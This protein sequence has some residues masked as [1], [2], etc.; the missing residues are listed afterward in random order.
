MKKK[1]DESIDELMDY[2]KKVY[3]KGKKIS[4]YTIFKI[5]ISKL[6]EDEI[7][8]KSLAVAF[9]F[10]LAVFPAIIFLFTLIPYIT[11]IIPEIDS[12]VIMNFL[13]QIMPQNM[14]DVTEE[15][16]LDLVDTKRGGLLSIGVLSALFLSTN[17]FNTLIKTFNS[18][19]RVEENRGFFKTRIIALILT[20]LS[21]FIAIF[22]IAVSIIGDIVITWLNENNLLIYG[23]DYYSII[24][25]GII[26]LFI[27][28]YLL[29]TSMYYF[30]PAVHNKWN[31][32]SS[33]ATIAAIGCV[34]I[35]L[36]FSFYL[37][38]FSVYNKVYGSIGAL[39]A[40][41]G[42]IYIFSSVLLVGFE[43]NTSIDLAIKKKFSDKK[44]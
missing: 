13:A 30:A 1:I 25:A 32:F 8:E 37:N 27:F 9:S 18:C 36:I 39:I 17:G 19:H 10:T 33:G 6:I 42:Y 22:T 11:N 7:F 21:S 3:L 4:I 31:F 43:W 24:L 38:N 40:F 28:F 2:S 34:G 20:L 12:D 26:T 44:L 29:I 15:T 16:I 41:M 23:L 35:S 5:F 14:Y